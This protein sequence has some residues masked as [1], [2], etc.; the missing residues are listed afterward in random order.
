[1]KGSWTNEEASEPKEEVSTPPKIELMTGEFVDFAETQESGEIRS[2]TLYKSKDS[3]NQE[4]SLDEM[5]QMVIQSL[6]KI[7]E[8]VFRI[9]SSYEQ[10]SEVC[11]MSIVRILKERY[12]I[13]FQ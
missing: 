8:K 4:S 2:V 11:P 3:K 12:E 10:L 1:V 13:R 6:I 9:W 7:S 5:A